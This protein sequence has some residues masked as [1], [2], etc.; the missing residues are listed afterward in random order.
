MGSRS[1]GRAILTGQGI[2]VDGRINQGELMKLQSLLELVAVKFSEGKLPYE[3]KDD[4]ITFKASRDGTT[5]HVFYGWNY[6][7][8]DTWNKERKDKSECKLCFPHGKAED[9]VREVWCEK[10]DYNFRQC[11]YGVITIYLTPAG[12][13]PL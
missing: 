5:L 4:K 8:E 13:C 1:L 11:P 3:F 12:R 7:P 10:R 2:W 9:P 6:P